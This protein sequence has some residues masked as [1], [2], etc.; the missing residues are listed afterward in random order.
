MS[1]IIENVVYNSLCLQ[2]TNNCP[3]TSVAGSSKFFF[4][5]HRRQSDPTIRK[6]LWKAN[7]QVPL[8]TPINQQIRSD[9]RVGRALWFFNGSV[10]GHFD[11][12]DL[13]VIKS[14]ENALGIT[15]GV[16]FD[17]HWKLFDISTTDTDASDKFP[18]IES[19]RLDFDLKLKSKGENSPG[20]FKIFMQLC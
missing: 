20:L 1:L 3:K 12:D 18:L 9:H 14:T 10:D 11:A 5:P 2:A 4:H 16:R 6:V 13:E 19:G 17:N 7:F 8:S 15:V